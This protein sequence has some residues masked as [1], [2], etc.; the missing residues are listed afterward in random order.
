MD[1]AVKVMNNGTRVLVH[2]YLSTQYVIQ[3][4]LELLPILAELNAVSGKKNATAK[5]MHGLM[6]Y[7]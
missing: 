2:A 4:K 7:A 5:V 1:I 3:G 6:T